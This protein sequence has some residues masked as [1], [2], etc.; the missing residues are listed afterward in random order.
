MLEDLFGFLDLQEQENQQLLNSLEEIM[1]IFIMKEIVGQIMW[2]HFLTFMWTILP[3]F[4]IIKLHW[5][6]NLILNIFDNV[7]FHTKYV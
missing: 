1:D 7:M 4:R 3:C 2:I 6:W 5:R